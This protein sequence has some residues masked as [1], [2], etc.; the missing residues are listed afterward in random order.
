MARVETHE[1]VLD[2]LD[3]KQAMRDILEAVADDARLNAKKGKTGGLV[4]GIGVEQVTDT[5]GIVVSRAVNPRS[6][7]EHAEY[8]YWVEK[9]TGRSRA[10]PYFR[11][12]AYAYRSL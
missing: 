2:Q 9:G 8:P 3:T 10:R 6:S 5:G 1:E 7:A 4:A 11:Q 12:A